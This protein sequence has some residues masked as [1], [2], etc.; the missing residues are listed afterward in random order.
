MSTNRFSLRIVCCLLCVVCITGLLFLFGYVGNSATRIKREHGLLLPASASQFVCRGD[1][2]ISFL[3][4]EAISEFLISRYDLTQF[5]NQLKIRTSDAL[6]KV[7]ASD[8]SATNIATYYCN[9]PTGDFLFVKL[10]V[11]DEKQVGVRL[12]TDWN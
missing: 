2:W 4:R 12:Y 11:A 6:A 1:A 3:D 5:T 10:W 8:N 7:F 9:S